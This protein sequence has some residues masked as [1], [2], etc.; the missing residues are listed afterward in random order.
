MSDRIIWTAE[1]EAQ[2]RQF[3]IEQRFTSEEVSQQVGVSPRAVRAKAA[4]MLAGV[5]GR[6]RAEPRPR[7][8][9]VPPAP[10]PKP[11]PS[12]AKVVDTSRAPVNFKAPEKPTQALPDRI[13][14]ALSERP[15]SAVSLASVLGEKE[16]HVGIQ[17]A[18]LAHA[19]AV[20][21]GPAT[22]IGP[23]HRIWSIAA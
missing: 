8:V 2:L 11:Q 18:A 20:L 15:L 13:T 19:G 17:L 16:L 10:R 5:E 6:R 4:R 7:A 22:D 1:Q 23:R 21:A 14:A 12:R 3:Y 9:R